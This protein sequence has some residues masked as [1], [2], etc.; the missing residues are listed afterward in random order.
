MLGF[1]VTGSEGTIDHIDYENNENVTWTFETDCDSVEL[2]SSF[3]ELESG[4]D[5]LT[6]AGVEH[7]GSTP[8][9][10]TV[11]LG[12]FVMNFYSDSS[13]AQ[14]GFSLIWACGSTG[15]RTNV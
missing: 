6:I 14:G 9:S 10:Q 2:N 15:T 4:Y 3:F 7:T 1:T 8:V 5:M 11:E 12:S 13:V